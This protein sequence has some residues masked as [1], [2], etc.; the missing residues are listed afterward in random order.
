VIGEFMI[1]NSPI[2]IS[3]DDG[4]STK[5]IT[6]VQNSEEFIIKNFTK[7]MFDDKY[8]G[9]NVTAQMLSDG[10]TEYFNILSAEGL[11]AHK[12]Y[13]KALKETAI[14][15][16]DREKWKKYYAEKERFADVQ[17]GYAMTVHKS[18]GSTY[19]EV[20]IHEIDI[21]LNKRIV[22]RNQCRYVAYSRASKVVHVYNA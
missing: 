6:A 1:A 19:S 20:F 17:Y 10:R 18:Q 9:F 15:D 5:Q 3:F 7:K 2:K 11:K 13:L 21:E 16:K 22:E 4:V 14:V 8:A 12:R